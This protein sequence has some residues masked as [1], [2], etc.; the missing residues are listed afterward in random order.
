VGSLVLS[1][2]PRLEGRVDPRARFVSK[3]VSY[4]QQPDLRRVV[5]VERDDVEDA[6]LAPV[7]GQDRLARVDQRRVVGLALVGSVFSRET[8]ALPLKRA[9][10]AF[11]WNY[12][13]GELGR[14]RWSVVVSD[15]PVGWAMSG[16]FAISTSSACEYCEPR[17]SLVRRKTR[18]GKRTRSLPPA[19]GEQQ[20][21]S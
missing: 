2:A 14:G 20:Q 7:A 4:L 10:V 18:F 1:P 21:E 16:G 11:W 3:T 6:Q 12:D 15:L 17:R 19:P 13:R 9:A 5:L 8:A